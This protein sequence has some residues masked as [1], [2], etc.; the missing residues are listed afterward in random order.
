MFPISYPVSDF[1]KLRDL[2]LSG[3]FVISPWV[4]DCLESNTAVL[5]NLSLSSNSPSSIITTSQ[6]LSLLASNP[7]IRRLALEESLKI[8]NDSE[9]DSDTCVPLCHLEELSLKGDLHQLFPILL[10]LELPERVDHARLE[11]YDRHFDAREIV[12][13]YIRNY[14][15]RD[16]R[17]KD[18][19]GIFVSCTR[20]R[21]S[22]R[23]CVIAVEYHG[24]DGLAAT[25]SPVCD[26]FGDTSEA[27]SSKRNRGIVHRRP[28]APPPR[29]HCLF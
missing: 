15:H 7:N 14:L 22:L 1:P 11:F 23:A 18:R 25:G 17:F 3:R 8:K 5:V 21:L 29:K 13:P 10:R 6:I 19:L 24:P 4:L 26:V 27:C 2:S 16:Q 12:A 9:R 28:R 20:G